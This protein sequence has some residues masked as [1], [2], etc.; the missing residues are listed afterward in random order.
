VNSIASPTR[1][2]FTLIIIYFYVFSKKN[3]ASK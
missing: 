2:E 1:G 3:Q